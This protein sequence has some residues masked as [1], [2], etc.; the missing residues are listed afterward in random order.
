M[1]APNLAVRN[2]PDTDVL[3]INVVIDVTDKVLLPAP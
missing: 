1:K 2:F 3:T